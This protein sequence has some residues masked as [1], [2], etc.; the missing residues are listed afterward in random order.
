MVAIT[1]D[2]KVKPDR[3]AEFIELAL[4]NA[5]ASVREPG[6]ARFDLLRDDA[7]PCRFTL[8]EI[9]RGPEAMAAHRETAH[10]L[11]YKAK[12]EAFEAEP[13][14][15]RTHSVLHPES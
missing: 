11:N 14:S 4:G 2:I 12:I 5:R 7:D 9:Y 10:Y 3:V 15:R 6:C 13:R 8:Y 1:V